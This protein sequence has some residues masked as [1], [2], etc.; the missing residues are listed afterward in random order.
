MKSQSPYI[1]RSLRAPVT[2]AFQFTFT[3]DGRVQTLTI[4]P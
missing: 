2:L 3:G 1:A 4:R